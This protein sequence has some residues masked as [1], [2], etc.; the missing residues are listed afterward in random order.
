MKREV[1]DVGLEQLESITKKIKSSNTTNI[2]TVNINVKGEDFETKTNSFYIATQMV[3]RLVSIFEIMKEEVDCNLKVSND[4]LDM[5]TLY[6]D[7]TVAI[8]V[9]FDR[10]IFSEFDVRG[11]APVVMCLNLSVL[12]KKLT[13]LQKFKPQKISLSICDHK[14]NLAGYNDEGNCGTVSLDSISTLIDDLDTE[15][16]QY[17]VL[18]ALSSARLQKS[19]DCM[20]AI[21]S[22]HM[23]CTNN[24]IR[25][26]GKEEMSK[27]TLCIP[28]GGDVIDEVKKHPSIASY[29]GVFHKLYLAPLIKSC[30]LSKY[31]TIGLHQEAPLFCRITIVDSIGTEDDSSVSMYFA[32]RF[33]D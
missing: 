31:V 27:T 21:F 33:G 26:E 23:D 12:A 8:F 28:L 10:D 18:I 4:G 19:L 2:R 11:E 3:R 29:S 24:N 15:N 9:H 1:T 30:K 17:Q 20:P 13:V 5:F 32:P 6:S 7:K 22:I 16:F 14:L 25:F